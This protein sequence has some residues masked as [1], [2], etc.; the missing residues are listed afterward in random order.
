VAQHRQDE[1]ITKL[2]EASPSFDKKSLLM[3]DRGKLLATFQQV[4]QRG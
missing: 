2:A 3:V 1:I 4:A